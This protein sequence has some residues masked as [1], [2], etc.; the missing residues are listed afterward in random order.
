ME[1]K[2]TFYNIQY[3]FKTMKPI[4]SFLLDS[5]LAGEESLEGKLLDIKV[6]KHREKRSLDS[7]AYFHV[8]VDKLA[9]VLGLSRAYMKNK[10]ISE[11][12]QVWY[13]DDKALVCK[14]NVPPSVAHNDE[15]NHMWLIKIGEDDAYWYKLYRPTHDYNSEEMSRLIQGTVEECKEQGIETATPE[16]LQK[17]EI[18]WKEKYERSS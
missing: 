7:N 5:D 2:G 3:D 8:L 15:F 9:G 16:E 17:M 12:G 1:L 10:L 4:I 11:Y 14:T 18:L 6:V 13:M